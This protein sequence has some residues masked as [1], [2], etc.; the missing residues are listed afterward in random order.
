MSS[1]RKPNPLD[2][3]SPSQI[4]VLQALDRYRWLFWPAA[5]LVFLGLFLRLAG[6]GVAAGVYELIV[7][8]PVLLAWGLAAYGWGSVPHSVRR[9]P[10]AGTVS[11]ALVH[12]SAIAVGLG[13]MSLA[14]LVLGLVGG[15]NRAVAVGL[16]AAGDV[17]AV[18]RL[19]RLK[20]RASF[21][22]G[23]VHWPW[24]LLAPLAALTVLCALLPAGLLWG[25][26]EPNGYDVVGYHLQVPREWYE[27]G[28]ITGLRHNV[29]SYFPFNVEMQY[30]LAMHL[31]GG[32]WAGQ[33][34]SQLMHA[35]YMALF[36]AAVYATVRATNA[37]TDAADASGASNESSSKAIQ[38]PLDD[39]Q[40][41]RDARRGVGRAVLAALIAAAAPWVPMLGAIAYNE[42]GLLLY[43]TL[44]IGW[45]L[46]A[47]RRTLN[48]ERQEAAVQRSAF[49]G[50]RFALAGL[51]AGLATGCKLT[52][53]PLLL[54][55]IP[56]AVL[57]TRPRA[58]KQLG[59]FLLAGVVTFGPWLIRNA[60]W[61]GNPV[62][63]EVQSLLGRGHFT[64]DQSAR[65]H[66]AHKP[67][68]DQQAMTVRLAEFGRQVVA[69]ARFAY[70]VVPL[71][72]VAM[73][74]AFRRREA[75]LLLVLLLI[76]TAFWLVQTHLQGRF[77][78]LAI[79]LA[80]VA[81]GIVPWRVW[82]AVAW[83]AAVVLMLAGTAVTYER[84]WDLHADYRRR[85]I[86][87]MQA[88]G[89]T[90]IDNT[91][92]IANSLGREVTDPVVLVGDAKAFFYQLPMSRLYYR[93]VFD[94]DT[95]LPLSKAY[96][97]GVP[98]G[99]VVLWVDLDELS[100]FHATYGLP[101]PDGD[102]V[103]LGVRSPYAVEYVV[104]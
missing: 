70:G 61:T 28:Q 83:P 21:A 65:W 32:P 92:A 22:V 47:E 33:F 95:S 49:C 52:A 94:V 98:S 38:P 29:Y 60:V 26:D 66:R 68:P 103:R 54:V 85:G 25:V 20:P 78:V 11:P 73:I 82:P 4:S 79:P 30:L 39:P 86:E 91:A 69:D 10:L 58:W 9:R 18:W 75:R 87:L 89:A 15:L 16:I 100:R 50:Q 90:Q 8:L 88:M 37:A 84:L 42:G 104:P 17:L 34:L 101:A 2:Y 45:I 24:L 27:A 35:T 3:A 99:R 81:V 53:V 59:V 77:Y 48:A 55:G 14:V 71:G 56:V 96:T 19:V 31:M 57:L 62:F 46:N 74:L 102:L 43:G 64:A 7:H 12:V 63:P 51:F 80:A 93:S 76:L 41:I 13:V 6:D 23:L 40:R 97:A 44:A 5:G 1:R 72:I 67:R 36:I